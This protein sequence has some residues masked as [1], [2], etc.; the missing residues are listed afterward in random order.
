MTNQI[1]PIM[2][3]PVAISGEDMKLCPVVL[4][5]NS[6]AEADAF[7]LRWSDEIEFLEGGE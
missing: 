4:V 6:D 1:K 5:F 7:K 3:F 2:A